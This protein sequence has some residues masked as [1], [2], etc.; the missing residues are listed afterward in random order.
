MSWVA[1][2]RGLG[3]ATH[4]LEFTI[5][6]ALFSRRGLTTS[7]VGQNLT[8]LLDG[9][10]WG[11]LEVMRRRVRELDDK[12][13]IWRESSRWMAWAVRLAAACLVAGVVAVAA[14]VGRYHRPP[15]VLDLYL[16]GCALPPTSWRARSTRGSGRS[17]ACSARSIR[18]PS[19]IRSASSSSPSAGVGSARGASPSGWRS[20]SSRRARS[21][22]PTRCAP[23]AW[24]ACPRRACAGRCHAAAPRR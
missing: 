20:P 17:G 24:R 22:S 9:A 16:L 7:V 21:S 6:L 18:W 19:A 11:A 13:E 10:W 8:L 3:T 5:L 14:R 4:L 23:I 12:A 1:L 15:T 2:M